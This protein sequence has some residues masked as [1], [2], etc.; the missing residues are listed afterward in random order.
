MPLWQAV[1][2][3]VAQGITEFLPISSTAHL[4][5]FPWLF[6]WRDPG[7]AFD[8][9]L[10]VGTLGAVL[11][12]FYKT[13]VDLLLLGLGRKPVFL[14]S[15]SSLQNSSRM[16][17]DRH[18]ALFWFLVLATIPAAVAGWLFEKQVATTLRSPVVVGCALIAVAIPMAW[19]EKVSRYRKDLHSV[20]LSDSLWVGVA[21]A[22]A[23]I[24]GVSRS[25]IT[26]TAALFRDFRREA[27][28]RFSFLLSTPIIAGAALKALL[29]VK[30]Q[31]FPPEMRLPVLVGVIV[32][33]LV[34]YAAIAA[35]LRFLQFGTFKIFIYYRIIL[36]IIVLALA[37]FFHLDAA[38]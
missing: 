7:L 23:L 8:V 11:L 19:G 9:A 2:L 5:L 21:Q 13:W 29:D 37:F 10:H 14:R 31:E 3:A 25:G 38:L 26:I 16:D 35:F 22:F 4:V 34:G 28:A 15:D 33:G 17:L 32:S 20:T 27:A 18:R 12:Y 24:P 6:R 36:G 1:V 30:G